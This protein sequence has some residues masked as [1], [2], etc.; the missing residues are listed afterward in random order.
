[1]TAAARFK[2]LEN[3]NTTVT[4][5]AILRFSDSWQLVVRAKGVIND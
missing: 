1:M 5:T 3:R 2:L 4:G